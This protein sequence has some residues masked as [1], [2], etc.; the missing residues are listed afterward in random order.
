[1][2]LAQVVLGVVLLVLAACMTA[3]HEVLLTRAN[4]GVRLPLW[5]KPSE[6]PRTPTAAKVLIGLAVGSAIVGA[7]S[8]D[9]ASPDH[10]GWWWAVLVGAVVIMP[11]ILTRASLRYL[12][13]W[14]L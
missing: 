5:G 10:I 14:S 11:P 6:T 4:P 7:T 9:A 8:L 3:A 12:R 2:A 1:M 13:T